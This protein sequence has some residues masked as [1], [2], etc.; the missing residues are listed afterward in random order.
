LGLIPPDA[1]NEGQPTLGADGDDVRGSDDEDAFDT[2]LILTPGETLANT[3]VRYHG[4]AAGGRLSGWIDFNLDGDWDDLGEQVLSDVEIE[5]GPGAMSLSSVT[6]PANLTT[7]ETFFRLRVSSDIGLTPRGLASDGEVE[8]FVAT[9]GPPLPDV[10][11]LSLTQT[12]DQE[13]PSLGEQIEFTLTVRN[14][15]P[16]RATGVE[17][18][19]FLPFELTFV[20]A[21]TTQGRYDDFDE[22]WEVGRLASGAS[23]V[24][25]IV[26]EVDSTDSISHSAEV[27]ASDQFDPDSTP[28]NGIEAEDDQQTVSIGT[29]L[30]RERLPGGSMGFVYACA[31]QPG[32]MVAFAH[33]TARG[34]THFPQ[35]GVTVD[36]A[37]A[38]VFAMAITDS[39]G[40]AR[41]PELTRESDAGETFL[42]Q[43]FELGPGAGKSNTI[44]FR[45]REIDPAMPVIDLA[46]FDTNR[47][48]PIDVN[49][50]GRITSLDALIVI[51]RL[52]SLAGSGEFQMESVAGGHVYPDTNGDGRLTAHDALL[53][54][55]RLAIKHQQWGQS[56]ERRSDWLD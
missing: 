42:T 23:A 31:A 51:N 16:D 7:G 40:F 47:S 56:K 48:D 12:V 10:A 13:N 17:V 33:S 14:D 28:D 37:E 1:E 45:A 32:A 36:M 8:D 22:V 20:T 34:E 29:C 38:E 26:V 24:L 50:D 25:R 9:I 49:D 27:I 43:A 4:G 21:S 19:T 53:V 11:D 15:G 39:N 2:P 18:G 6:A 52:G 3:T 46:T 30:T 54:I 5:A 41:V 35:Y 44:V 55:N